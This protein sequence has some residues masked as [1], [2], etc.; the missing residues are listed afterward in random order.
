MKRTK[1]K[2][3]LDDINIHIN[4]ILYGFFLFIGITSMLFISVNVIANQQTPTSSIANTVKAE[5]IQTLAQGG[6]KYNYEW[7]LYNYASGSFEVEAKIL[8]FNQGACGYRWD[9]SYNEIWH[10]SGAA[11]KDTHN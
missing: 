6:M 4:D 1:D 9:P 2:V 5:N 11:Q 7:G 3:M 8:T 10:V